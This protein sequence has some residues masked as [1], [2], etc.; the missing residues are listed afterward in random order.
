[1]VYLLDPLRAAIRDA[2][3]PRTVTLCVEDFEY[4]W[5]LVQ[6]C[7]CSQELDKD[8]LPWVFFY[9]SHVKPYTWVIQP[10]RPAHVNLSD[11][12]LF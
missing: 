12:H 11:R 5:P 4:L 1:M 7:D 6:P 2:G 3:Y 8:G 9:G 10:T